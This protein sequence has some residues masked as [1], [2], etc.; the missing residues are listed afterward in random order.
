MGGL[1]GGYGHWVNLD[2][3]R[4]WAI[5]APGTAGV[6]RGIIVSSYL[7]VCSFA[8]T[9]GPVSWTYPAEIFPMRVVSQFGASYR[10]GDLSNEHLLFI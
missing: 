8:L 7:F 5:D 1:Q 6:T 10:V 9:M 4:I 3:E 2:G